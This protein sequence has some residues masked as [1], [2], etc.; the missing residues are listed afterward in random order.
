MSE[1]LHEKVHNSI[2]LFAETL[3]TNPEALHADLAQLKNKPVYLYGA[4]FGGR[5]AIRHAELYPTDFDGYISHN[6]GLDYRTLDESRRIRGGKWLTFSPWIDPI[7]DVERI[8]RPLLLFHNMDDNNVNPKVTLSFAQKARLLNKSVQVQFFH[9]GNRSTD[10]N[11]GHF[12]PTDE[13][14]FNLY[15]ETILHFIATN[16]KSKIPAISDWKRHRY[17]VAASKNIRSADPQK[18]AVAEAYRLY[19][20]DKTPLNFE[21]A[22]AQSYKPIYDAYVCAEF[23]DQD[24]LLKNIQNQDTE[25]IKTL[26]HHLAYF[27]DYT[28]HRTYNPTIQEI[29]AMAHDTRLIE[30]FKQILRERYLL[31]DIKK[32]LI[33]EIYLANPHLLPSLCDS[34]LEQDGSYK[35]DEAKAELQEAILSGKERAQR[36]I[37]S[38]L[39]QKVKETTGFSRNVYDMAIIRD[40]TNFKNLPENKQLSLKEHLKRFS[41]S[42]P[43]MG[44]KLY[45]V[46][47]PVETIPPFLQ[48]AIQEAWS[49][50]E[51]LDL[52][53]VNIT[54][55]DFR[56]EMPH[57]KVL[58][59]PS[60]ITQWDAIQGLNN[61]SA[62]EELRL[63]DTQIKSLAFLAP[64]PHL[65]KLILPNT[66]ESLRGLE[67]LQAL[68]YLYL[69]GTQSKSFAFLTP[70]PHLKSVHL[71][72]DLISV[73]G[74]E[75]LTAL[76]E[77]NLT[78]TS[79]PEL[80]FSTP[81]PHLKVLDLPGNLRSL[82]GLEH[83][84]ALATLTLLDTKITTIDVKKPAPPLVS[85]LEILELPNTLE[86]LTGLENLLALKWLLYL[87]NT[88]ITALEFNGSMPYLKNLD[89]PKT[90]ESL[91]GLEHLTALERLNLFETQIKS[92]ELFASMRR[93]ETVFL[94]SD[95]IEHCIIHGERENWEVRSF[96]LT[97]NPN[98]K[99]IITNKRNVVK[100]I[101]DAVTS[102]EHLPQSSTE[103]RQIN[104]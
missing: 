68:E 33:R 99:Y 57:L 25:I 47:Q 22:W 75:Y 1:I 93:L 36:A 44:G 53:G 39:R 104:P 67:H 29:E 6:G 88:K 49:N 41:W 4:S 65:K 77:L 5:D 9:S 87:H 26:R 96:V 61:L 71:P 81:M 74:L 20:K 95:T 103:F 40:I 23:K 55:V 76:E 84:P 90:L 58:R 98:K 15:L 16:G 72:K 50:L 38:I 97:P 37:G 64:M 73:T 92:I 2:H 12:L 10:Y 83:L 66:L 28:F 11:K 70:M 8:E 51:A 102:G 19:L 60:T 54:S 59:L 82:T 78:W 45:D 91:T 35:P 62:L 24:A 13:E 32:F 63:S 34:R 48:D 52:Y 86:S 43:E 18:K 31:E 89:L 21:T 46:L 56:R 94:P 101:D 85:H 79:I 100:F 80:A 7:N 42:N 69:V 14:G 3:K 27:V 30:R 17:G